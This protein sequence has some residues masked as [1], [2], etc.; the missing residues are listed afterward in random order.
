MLTFVTRT[1]TRLYA[2]LRLRRAAAAL[3]AIAGGVLGCR[4]RPG[5]SRTGHDGHS[6]GARSAPLPERERGIVALLRGTGGRRRAGL[7]G[8][9][10]QAGIGPAAPST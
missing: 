5:D 7:V 4:S 3:A 8:Y 9:A 6:R 10:I 1:A 2:S